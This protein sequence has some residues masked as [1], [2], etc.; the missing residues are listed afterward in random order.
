MDMVIDR[1]E[2]LRGEGTV[3]SFLLRESDGKRCCVGIYARALGVPD[4][5]TLNCPWP[6]QRR[7]YCHIDGSPFSFGVFKAH[8]DYDDD[9]VV[10]RADEAEW[11]ISPDHGLGGIND[12][13]TMDETVREEAI[14]A[15]FAKHGVHV[16]FIN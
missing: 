7:C 5:Q 4:T 2:W 9:P 12:D 6:R 13:P 10:W 15:I 3:K 1:T 16:S 8:A 14:T 11:L